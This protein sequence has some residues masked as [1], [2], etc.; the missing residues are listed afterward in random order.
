MPSDSSHCLS[1]NCDCPPDACLCA[2]AETFNASQIRLA[3]IHRYGDHL[4]DAI[5]KFLRQMDELENPR[6]AGSW[7]ALKDALKAYR[8]VAR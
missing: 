7:F 8:E 2:F 3:E 1:S 6:P 4:A 5:E